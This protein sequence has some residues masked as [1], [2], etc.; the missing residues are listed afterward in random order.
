MG[1]GLLLFRAPRAWQLALPR[2][3]QAPRTSPIRLIPMERREHVSLTMPA[4]LSV[5]ELPKPVLVNTQYGQ[6]AMKWQ[7][8]GSLV[9][10]DL[11]IRVKGLT[12]PSA[13]YNLLRAFLDTATAAEEEPILLVNRAP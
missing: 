11:T 6:V 12:V 4:G 3:P 10:R 5:D 9:T 2:L 13:E 7:L 1:G 8:E